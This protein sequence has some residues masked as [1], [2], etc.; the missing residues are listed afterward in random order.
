MLYWFDYAML[1][2]TQD[3]V[4]RIKSGSLIYMTNIRQFLHFHNLLV[5]WRRSKLKFFE[6]LIIKPKQR[7]HIHNYRSLLSERH[8][9][10][11]WFP[12]HDKIKSVFEKGNFCKIK[13]F[14]TIF[15]F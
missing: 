6:N 13:S 2:V 12:D 10:I 8:A 7:S 5:Y 3:D 9:N 11:Y 15:G 1:C 4:K 14:Q